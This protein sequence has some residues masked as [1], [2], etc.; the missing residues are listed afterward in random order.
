MWQSTEKWLRNCTE[1]AVKNFPR[2]L[3]HGSGSNMKIDLSRLLLAF[4]EATTRE[5]V[6]V[7]LRDFGL[8]LEDAQ[9]TEQEKR[10]RPYD[11]VN[12]TDRRF[13]VR[14]QM[15]RPIDQERFEILQNRLADIL[16]WIGPVYY[17]GSVLGRGGLLCP[18]P[19]ILLIRP[20]P[21][22][23][24]EQQKD[25]D[26]RLRSYGVKEVREKS[27]YLGD[28]HYYV[29]LD[30]KE[31]N[32]YHLQDLLLQQE[33]DLVSAVHFENMPMINPATVV[34]N[35]TFF[36]QQW[37]MTR[38][39][40]GGAG[41]TGWDISTGATGVI[42]CIL[43]S[44]CDLTH[45]DL[46]FAPGPAGQGI[47]LGT[48]MPT[49]APAVLSRPHGTACAG[50]A[51]AIFNNT[52]GI[53]GVAGNCSLMPVAFQNWT[54]AECAAGINWAVGNGAHVISM[55]FG[56]YAPAMGS[57]PPAGTSPSLIL[58]SRMQ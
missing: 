41:T 50:L 12:H 44:G 2:E 25:L 10:A 38:I 7:R 5:E 46:N 33:K 35:D 24:E 29:L 34:S 47:N 42:I 20:I 22:L 21:R 58:R 48:M 45:P 1:V 57:V 9:D 17:L 36:P 51:A 39:Q 16:D 32:S 54:D 37:S 6:E 14:S 31:R 40:A 27:V 11:I 55:S 26:K 19:N 52:A 53:S 49:G 8:V 4:K 3:T 18:L 43:D 30:I 56:Y 15:G 28:Y 23:N 13:W